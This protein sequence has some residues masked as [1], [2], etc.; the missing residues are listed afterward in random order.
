MTEEVWKD[1]K[2]DRYD[3]SKYQ[4]SNLGFIRNKETK[5]VL[6]RRVDRTI[7]GYHCCS[8]Q[9]SGKSKDVKV[10]R[11]VAFA[12]CKNLENKP[13]VD[14][15]NRNKLDDRAEN[16]RWVTQKENLANQEKR[17]GKYKGVRTLKNSHFDKKIQLEF[18]FMRPPNKYIANCAGE[19]LG[20]FESEEEAAKAY[21]K[22][23]K[24]VW[25]GY[26]FLNFNNI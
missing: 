15:I 7:G 2:S 18:E 10:S 9:I 20:C 13:F 21:D 12:F 17:I 8:L 24:P 22:K 26:A 16:L 25:G 5:K 4:V 19:H 23:A 14:H 11:L 1:A 3:V 6:S